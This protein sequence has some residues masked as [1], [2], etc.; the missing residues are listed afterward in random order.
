[1]PLLLDDIAS[2]SRSK[3]GGSQGAVA[4]YGE[5]IERA[6][7]ELRN[8]LRK[9]KD[10]RAISLSKSA[11]C[12][13]GYGLP[14]N[15]A[16]YVAA[17]FTIFADGVHPM[18]LF[19]GES[20]FDLGIAAPKAAMTAT[21][22]MSPEGTLLAISAQCGQTT[23]CS[24][25]SDLDIFCAQSWTDSEGVVHDGTSDPDGHICDAYKAINEAT[26]DDISMVHF[27]SRFSA[28]SRQRFR[29]APPNFDPTVD[30]GHSFVFRV[31]RGTAGDPAFV[32]VGG[33]YSM[34]WVVRLKQGS[35]VI[36]TSPTYAYGD[37]TDWFKDYTV[38]LSEAEG[39][40]ITDYTNLYLECALTQSALDSTNYYRV[41]LAL[42]H[43]VV[44]TDGVSLA[45]G[46][47]KYVYTWVRTATGV[48][49]GPSPEL[50]HDH[51]TTGGVCL[52]GILLSE[53]P[54][55]DRM[56]IYR[57]T[58]LGSEFVLFKTIPNSNDGIF[59]LCGGTEGDLDP[60]LYADCV[61]DLTQDAVL[62]GP[63]AIILQVQNKRTYGAGL[64]TRR[65]CVCVHQNSVVLAGAVLDRP[66]TAGTAVFT[67]G[68]TTVTG[69]GTVWTS[70]L[71]G[72]M[73]GPEG[74]AD[75]QKY[76]IA[77]VRSLTEIELTTAFTDSTVE[78]SYAIEDLRDP[79][80][81]DWS[82]PGFPEDVPVTNNDSIEGETGEGITALI[83]HFGRLYLFTRSNI[84]ERT[85][86]DN[87]NYRTDIVYRGVGAVSQAATIVAGNLIYFRS[88][89]GIYAFDG[90]TPVNLSNPGATNGEILGIQATT[91]ALNPALAHRT[92]ASWNIR[93][94]TVH[95]YVPG[96]D[97]FECENALVLDLNT[98][99]WAEDD[100]PSVCSAARI[101]DQNANDAYLVGG[102]QGDLWQTNL[103]DSHSDGAFEGTIVSRITSSNALSVTCDGA[104]FPT[105]NDGLY[106]L[107]VYLVNRWGRAI[108]M[109]VNSN[110][111]TKIIFNYPLP[112]PLVSRWWVVVGAIPMVAAS[113][114]V[115][116]GSIH[117][118]TI[119]QYVE[120]AFTPADEGNLY[121]RVGTDFERLL[122]LDQSVDL[123][124]ERGT[125]KVFVRTK[126]KHTKFEF[127]S[128]I[129]GSPV[130]I[131]QI[132]YQLAASDKANGGAEG[133]Q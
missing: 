99:T 28:T 73:I 111:A 13:I 72:R 67:N 89:D 8:P 48:E 10:P 4:S 112:F 87:S 66:Y 78:G 5:P 1:M 105:T 74:A 47:Y 98:R 115:N 100:A 63:N 51:A 45:A 64:P 59:N 80:G 125:Q 114:W 85:G 93:D 3:A 110:S 61:E 103:P 107:P 65:R 131:T 117:K 81:Y 70:L 129:P 50:I 49:S 130:E 88:P 55:V 97:E 71:E 124:D 116:W 29:F 18:K 101:P 77:R 9:P 7:L 42:A 38:N 102:L 44:P 35:T 91:N 58:I 68:S 46:T 56:R 113:G 83:S 17:D 27:E 2:I 54:T 24:N 43:P 94:N 40:S 126:A 12:E 30:T 23:D 76:T 6:T 82:A 106:A 15:A 16:P 21:D 104:A 14:L 79:C 132:D 20:C 123:S 60:T 34:T 57:T 37:L 133:G 62:T 84:Y 25:P 121:L 119:T 109:R 108:R 11:L 120:A 31:R 127:F 22:E 128:L 90:Q 122:L 95:F 39:A 69:T 32:G 26:T 36:A 92:V 52:S 118:P 33:I 75:D 53:D 19:N 86:N 41:D 96:E